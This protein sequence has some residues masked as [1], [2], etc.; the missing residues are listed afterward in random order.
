MFL[1]IIC[2][3]VQSSL[4]RKLVRGSK[5]TLGPCFDAVHHPVRS[6]RIFAALVALQNLGVPENN[7]ITD[8]VS[9]LQEGSS[10]NSPVRERSLMLQLPIW[11][12]QAQQTSQPLLFGRS[13]SSLLCEAPYCRRHVAALTQ[14]SGIERKKRRLCFKN[15][16]HDNR[17]VY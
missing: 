5:R 6:Q 15:E 1:L 12:H 8:A 11:S 14:S 17:K 16:Q 2:M 13:P 3:R 10:L 9:K 7:A 4:K